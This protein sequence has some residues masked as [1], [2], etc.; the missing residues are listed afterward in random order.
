MGPGAGERGGEIV[1]DGSPAE[2]RA[3]G[4]ADRAPCR[5]ARCRRGDRR[6]A[7][8]TAARRRRRHGARRYG[9]Q[10]E[11]RRRRDP[12]APLVCVTGVS[13]SGKSTLVQDVL[14]A[15]LLQAKGKPTDTPARTR[16][17][18][19]ADLIDDVVMV[20][21]T[22]IGRTT[23]SNPASYVGA[24]DAIRKRFAR[25]PL[26]RER[27]YTAGTF[28]FNSGNGR[29]PDLRRQRLRARR[30]AVPLG[31]VPALPGLRR[32]ALPPRSS[33]CAS[34]AMTNAARD[35]ADVLEMTV[36]EALAF[37]A[38][39]AVL[40]RLEAAR[41]RRPRLPE[42][43]PAGADAVG[44]RGAA[45][46][47]R[48]PSRRPHFSTVGRGCASAEYFINFGACRPQAVPVRRAD[49]R[50]A[51][52]R[53]REAARARSK[54]LGRGPFAARDRA[55]PRRDPRRRLDHRPRPRGRR[56]RRPSARGRH[57]GRAWPAPPRTPG[58]RSLE[59]L[60]RWPSAAAVLRARR[61]L[62]PPI[63]PSPVRAR[64]GGRPRPRFDRRAPRARAQPARHRRRDPARRHSR[65]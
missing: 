60:R 3:L 6:P 51:L 14:Y 48:R 41:R 12:A 7:T 16:A 20:D 26:A 5:V 8:R 61:A 25:A 46:E 43:R 21:Q 13:G 55:Q 33:R 63:A 35:I 36:T 64:R 62:V 65:C 23:R 40:A 47:A 19:G 58:A 49:H 28:S 37:F 27:G 22:P 54:L 15:A 24:F 29:C 18:L 38:D 56:R 17:L 4:H 44:R 45:P 10:P 34:Q 52:R 31:R 53:R 50:P 39:A 30:D 9:A 42:A 2:L 11:R 57:A 1:F 32:Q 59:A